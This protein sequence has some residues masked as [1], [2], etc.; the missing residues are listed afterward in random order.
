[1][2]RIISFQAQT[3]FITVDGK[4]KSFVKLHFKVPNGA[5]DK[6]V[7]PTSFYVY[8]RQIPFAL[9]LGCDEY[10]Y[11]MYPKKEELFYCG[12]IPF[13]KGNAGFRVFI[14]KEVETTKTYGYWVAYDEDMQTLSC[15]APV[16]VRDPRVFWTQEKILSTMQRLT[17]QYK[18]T[19]MEQVGYTAKGMPLFALRIGNKENCVAL[20]GVVHAAESGP[21]I[22]LTVAEELLKNDAGLLEKT[23]LAIMPTVNGDMR[24]KFVRGN[25]WY[26]RTNANGVDINRNFPKD[27]EE[28][29]GEYSSST[30]DPQSET[31]RGFA[32]MCER[33]TQALVQFIETV[34]PRAVFSYHWL[35]SVCSDNFV[36]AG[37]QA[38]TDIP[39]RTRVEKMTRIYS[40]AF[41]DAINEPR[42]PKETV[43]MVGKPGTFTR[44]LYSKDIP[45][46]DVEHC[47]W[48]LRV[49]ADVKEK[50]ISTFET[51]THSI[52]GHLQG[53]KATL[54]YFE[55]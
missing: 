33:E 11:H 35:Y 16:T 38:I 29:N 43:F 41:R 49:F 54:E 14:D 36:G 12:E 32:P 31:Y 30:D 4:E 17:K 8:K 3:D 18:K 48:E 21:E 20:A 27:W 15:L 45:G 26:L 50:G 39:Y 34:K 7:Y 25:P 19:E 1:M 10:F 28:V 5:D 13:E 44:W 22:A 23:G 37:A 2:R 53:I 6:A 55:N 24:E 47:C 9:P 40:D 52:K 42:R 51:L 46:V